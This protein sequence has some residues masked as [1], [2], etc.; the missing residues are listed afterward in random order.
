MITRRME[1]FIYSD[2]GKTD[3]E[4]VGNGKD[5]VANEKEISSYKPENKKVSQFN[6]VFFGVK[7]ITW[8]NS[9]LINGTKYPRSIFVAVD[10]TSGVKYAKDNDGYYIDKNGNKIEND[11]LEEKGV[12]LI[13]GIQDSYATGLEGI[14]QSLTQRLSLIQ[15]ELYHFTNLGFPLT[16]NVIDKIPM[17]AYLSKTVLHHPNVLS[18]KNL[19]SQIVSHNYI[20]Y[21]NINTTAGDLNMTETE[22]V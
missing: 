18:I 3:V 20:A 10:S 14:S 1:K 16:N 2:E 5:I 21:I 6:L 9:I 7:G 19:S 22:E 15:G 12:L 13:K 8:E 17:D 4:I 11:K